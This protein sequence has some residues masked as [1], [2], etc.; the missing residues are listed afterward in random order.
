LFIQLYIFLYIGGSKLTLF[1]SEVKN[2]ANKNFEVIDKEKWEKESLKEFLQ[3]KVSK[4][5]FIR[6]NGNLQ[7]AQI[8]ELT[9]QITFQS[10]KEVSGTLVISE[11]IELLKTYDYLIIQE[12]G[13]NIGYINA[14]ELSKK[15][16]NSYEKMEAY[17][18]TVTKTI[19]SSCTVIDS[20]QNVMIWTKG[21]EKIFSVKQEDIIGKKI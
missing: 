21:A 12:N 6:K 17:F 1:L 9:N 7:L 5:I 15:V 10:C 3:S 14:L 11:V 4:K 8:S 16:L 13:E 19:D 18:Q 2:I 20:D